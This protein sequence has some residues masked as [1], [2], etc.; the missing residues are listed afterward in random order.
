MQIRIGNFYNGQFF[1][2][3]YRKRKFSFYS[4]SE[5]AKDASKKD[6]FGY[7]FIVKKDAP[8]FIIVPGG[9]YH[10]ICPRKEGTAFAEELN[11]MDYNAFV[12]NYRVYPH[13]HAPNPQEDLAAL[14]RYVFDNRERFGFTAEKYALVGFSAGGH[15]AASFGTKNVGYA[16][17][18]VPKPAAEILAYP[19]ITM[20]ENTHNGTMEALTDKDGDLKEKYSVEKNIDGD[21]PPTYIW[22]CRDDACVPPYNTECLE[23]ALTKNGVA[24]KKEIF[25]TGGH[26][27][28]LAYKKEADGWFDRAVAFT[29][30]YLRR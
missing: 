12:L 1:P 16:S 6:A 5:K 20:G 4:E 30:R 29:V 27:I 18:D 15:L 9:G 11:R 26:G 17:F 3:L 24:C 13:S 7:S 14:I 8:L 21:Y 22:C 19:V 25:A 10:K 28:G 23:D 2:F